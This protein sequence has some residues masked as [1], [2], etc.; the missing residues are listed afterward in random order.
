MVAQDAAFHQTIRAKGLRCQALLGSPWRFDCIA[1]HFLLSQRTPS[2]DI[3]HFQFRWPCQ[4]P[5]VFD[6]QHFDQDSPH[7]DDLPSIGHEPATEREGRADGPA[8]RL[9]SS[10][11]Y[12]RHRL[13]LHFISPG[14]IVGCLYRSSLC[15][16][17]KR[18][19][20][21][22]VWTSSAATDRRPD[23]RQR[24]S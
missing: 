8:A 12:R 15:K 9:N 2:L 6:A 11:L 23:S 1:R 24:H 10:H 4:L 16:G 13:L 22:D 5:G 3:T 21:V 18:N 14:C 17:G 7:L 20:E 19:N